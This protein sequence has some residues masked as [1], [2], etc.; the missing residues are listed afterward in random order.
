[1]VCCSR[2]SVV[3][4]YAVASV[5]CIQKRFIKANAYYNH[6]VK[7]LLH[8]QSKSQFCNSVEHVVLMEN[9]LVTVLFGMPCL[10]WNTSDVYFSFTMQ[11]LP[12]IYIHM[13]MC[14]IKLCF[15]QNSSYNN[16]INRNLISLLQICL[17]REVFNN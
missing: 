5:R 2:K 8:N 7:F 3:A 13:C 1:M 6:N 16:F 11:P 14:N 12:Q 9:I 17:P 4:G 15:S 10:L